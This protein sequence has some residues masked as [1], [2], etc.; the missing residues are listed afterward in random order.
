MDA[1]HP[2]LRDESVVV[3]AV[4]LPS[5]AEPSD[6]HS[7]LI[8]P[9]RALVP[10]HPVTRKESALVTRQTRHVAGLGQ[11]RTTKA[12]TIVSPAGR[13][14]V[15]LPAPKR[16]QATTMIPAFA[17]ARPRDQRRSLFGTGLVVAATVAVLIGALYTVSPFSP[18]RSHDADFAPSAAL[19]ALNPD[20]S[21]PG[22][23]WNTAAGTTQALGLGGGAGPG[24]D[25]PGSAGL[26][27]TDSSGAWNF[28]ASPGAVFIS[29]PPVSPWPPDDPF[30]EVPG[31]A[32]FRVSRPSDGFYWWAFGQCTWWAQF[33]RRDE[34]LTYL[35]DAREWPASA[36]DRG[37]R[38]GVKAAP[39]ASV[40]FRGGAQGAGGAG[41]VGHV[42]AVYPGGWFLVS[43]MNFYW[44]GG[45]WGYVDYRFAHEGWGVV[46]IY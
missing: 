36:A 5:G 20:S 26:P 24:V 44:N 21:A 31:H 11:T 13:E 33:Q 46:F 25:A 45:A 7:G 41:H 32:A 4:T 3:P 19:L 28:S 18:L 10:A 23:P 39:N 34:N 27:V 15:V 40:V 1:A 38:V 16:P 42:E 8:P 43:E 22:G 12:V 37:Y 14:T 30:M 29:A 2:E 6:S 35:G 17:P 9:R